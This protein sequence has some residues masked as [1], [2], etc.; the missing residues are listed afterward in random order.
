MITS[1]IY[2]YFLQFIR[3]KI[4]Y[5]SKF[6]LTLGKISSITGRLEK[7]TTIQENTLK[8]FSQNEESLKTHLTNINYQIAD[9]KISLQEELNKNNQDN[10]EDDYNSSNNDSEADDSSTICKKEN[11][12]GKIISLNVGKSKQN[13]SKSIIRVDKDALFDHLENKT[14]VE[15]KRMTKDYV[16]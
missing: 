14:S 3:D 8:D 2:N 1:N 7:I 10:D 15:K 9:L 5:T 4:N 12:G 13:S 11:S 6:K 16:S